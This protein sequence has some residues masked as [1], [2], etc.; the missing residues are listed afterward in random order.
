MA[1]D[2]SSRPQRESSGGESRITKFEVTHLFGRELHHTIRFPDEIQNKGEPSIIILFG[3][4]GC[5][6]TTILRMIDGMLNLNF[7]TFRQLPFDTAKLTL[8]SGEELSVKRRERRDFPLAV[9][10]DG[11]SVELARDKSSPNYSIKQEAD[12]SALRARAMPVLNSV[13]YELL[14]IH[15]SSALLRA[16]PEE[17]SLNQVIM[18]NMIVQGRS[19]GKTKDNRNMEG[20]SILAGRVRNFVR[21]AQVNYRK[22]FEAEQLELLPRILK[23]LSH[24]QNSS[25]EILFEKIKRIKEKSSNLTRMGL[26]TDESD[27]DSLMSV[28]SREHVKGDNASL[29]VL[30]AYVE[31]QENKDQT[32]D[33][34]ANRLVN[35]EKIM[36]DFLIG[37]T[38]KIDAIEG[39]K[40]TTKTGELKETDLS[41]GEYHF[42]YMMVSALLC[43]RTGSIIAIDEPELSLHVSWQRKIVSALARCAAG[44][45]PLFLFATHS[46]T[47]SAEHRDFVKTLGAED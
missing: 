33:L 45:S 39:L 5:G 18:A 25:R 7:D 37:K 36:A 35:F 43:L 19:I 14:D 41:S 44:A 15:R 8:S 26:Q 38:V 3:S 12:L 16:N 20:S 10:F 9:S 2:M 22:Y 34:I 23:R 1:E 46:S 32:R 47:I 30:E 27:L 31:M 42:L 11:L 29:A 13:S 17:A 40:I 24:E 4:N 21:E 6:K 28:L